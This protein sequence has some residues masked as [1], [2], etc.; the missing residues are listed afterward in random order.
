MKHHITYLIFY[1]AGVK[2]KKQHLESLDFYQIVMTIPF[3]RSSEDKLVTKKTKRYVKG[4]DTISTGVSVVSLWP[5][6][7]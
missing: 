6:N 7:K 5:L 3:F 2:K 4:I 1:L